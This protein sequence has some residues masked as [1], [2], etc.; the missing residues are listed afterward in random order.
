[1]G[2]FPHPRS[3]S[4]IEAL[5]KTINANALL[6]SVQCFRVEEPAPHFEIVV[7]GQGE[8]AIVDIPVRDEARLSDLMD[9]T[10]DSFLM[11]LVIRN[12][13]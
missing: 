9:Q 5:S 1:M 3:G 7:H 2:G 11:N 8:T 10:L 4:E 13:R 12:D 6:I